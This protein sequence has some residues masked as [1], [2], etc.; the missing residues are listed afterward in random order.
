MLQG[1]Y[2]PQQGDYTLWWNR[3]QS[4]L[5]LASVSASLW[6]GFVS[7]PNGWSGWNQGTLH[8]RPFPRGERPCELF[9]C[10]GR[11]AAGALVPGEAGWGAV[12]AGV[13]LLSWHP[14]KF[15]GRSGGCAERRQLLPPLGGGGG[16]GWVSDNGCTQYSCFPLGKGRGHP[17]VGPAL[18]RESPELFAAVEV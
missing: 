16:G 5:G 12:G 8:S 13:F 9:L 11:R 7:C 3:D 18:Q 2:L 15:A 4:G 14:T 1:D 6:L 10:L 17:S